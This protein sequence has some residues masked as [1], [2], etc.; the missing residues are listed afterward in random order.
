MACCLYNEDCGVRRAP[1]KK[2]DSAQQNY[3]FT[4]HAHGVSSS[5]TAISVDLTL[6]VIVWHAQILPKGGWQMI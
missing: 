3:L 6:R 1:L 2:L 5:H 4:Q